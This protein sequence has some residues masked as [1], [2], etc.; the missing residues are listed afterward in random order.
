MLIDRARI[1]ANG[2]AQGKFFTPD[3]AT[4][5][6]ET[7]GQRVSARFAQQTST[8]I[9]ASHDCDILSHAGEAEPDVTVYPVLPLR[10]GQ[11]F[12]PVSV[13]RPRVWHFEMLCDGT[14]VP[15]EVLACS[16]FPIPRVDL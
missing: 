3:D 4:R 5:L 13:Q 8:L 11:Q 12:M 16:A 10:D 6:V 14:K 7:H 15:R 9:L 1:A 2:W